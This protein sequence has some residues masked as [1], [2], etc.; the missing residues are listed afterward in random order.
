MASPT[1]EWFSLVLEAITVRLVGLLPIPS[2]APSIL[3]KTI[4]NAVFGKSA[5]EFL[6]TTS[7]T[8]YKLV[9]PPPPFLCFSV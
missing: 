2:G 3:D 4:C 1:D 6:I 7:N 8:L 5:G 9:P